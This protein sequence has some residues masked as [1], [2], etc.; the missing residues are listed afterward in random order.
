MTA[1]V[2]V[3]NKHFINGLRIF[4]EQW[5]KEQ[6]EKDTSEKDISEK[7]ISQNDTSNEVKEDNSQQFEKNN[8][9]ELATREA[10]QQA[11]IPEVN[12]IGTRTY[13][14]YRIKSGN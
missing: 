2:M 3:I 5:V 14:I 6:S 8:N 1:I 9:E 7:D 11:E 12:V 4:F 10:P 13:C